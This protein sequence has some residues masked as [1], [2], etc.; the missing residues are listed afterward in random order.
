MA[1]KE[2]WKV[3]DTWKSEAAFWGW[4]RGG[5]RK[6]WSRHPVKLEYIKQNRKRISNPN[7][8]GRVAEVWGMTCAIC[9]KDMVQSEI[10]ID[11]ISEHGARLSGLEDV[12]SFVNHLLMI[13]FN[14]LRPLCKP[15]HRVVSHAQKMGV[16]FEE[17]LAMKMAI[18]FVKQDK[19][20]VVDFCVQRGYNLSS[21]NTA[22]KRREAVEQIFLKGAKESV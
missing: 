6:L 5:L 14:S 16:S 8:K 1:N 2:P 21:L 9:Q 20:I 12:E 3:P 22:A 15:C 10:E 11:H 7:P 19:K 13:D 18:E 17:A 4:V